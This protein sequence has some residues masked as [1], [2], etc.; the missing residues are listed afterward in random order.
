MSI[1]KITSGYSS[2]KM[3]SYCSKEK[4]D[5]LSGEKI[6]RCT[7]W[8]NNL[9]LAHPEHVA[10]AW[11]VAR[12]GFGKCSGRQYHHASLSLDPKD[13]QAQKITDPEMIRMAEK[14]V[15]EYAPGHDYSIFIHRDKEHPH[16]HILWNSVHS[17]TGLKFHASKEDLRHGMEIKD[18][19]DHEFG[20][21][22]TTRNKIFDRI[23][24]PAKRLHERDQS[25]YLWMEDLKQRIEIIRAHTSDFSTY[26]ALLKQLGV[27]ADP[28]GKEGKV[29]YRFLDIEGKQRQCRE[30]KLGDDYGRETLERHFERNRE[31]HQSNAAKLEHTELD[32]S[33]Q[34]RIE[35]STRRTSSIKE[36]TSTNESNLGS[37]SLTT[38]RVYQLDTS[39]NPTPFK[40]FFQFSEQ[41]RCL[42]ELGERFISPHPAGAFRKDDPHQTIGRELERQQPHDI[43]SI[44]RQHALSERVPITLSPF[45]D[46]DRSS[47]NSPRMDSSQFLHSEDTSEQRRQQ[48]S[49]SPIQENAL[50]TQL[51]EFRHVVYSLTE[52]GFNP[53]ADQNPPR[54]EQGGSDR[55][56]TEYQQGLVQ[57]FSIARARA[58][59][60]YR[61]YSR[62]K[63]ERIEELGKTFSRAI[64]ENGSEIGRRIADQIQ[65]LSQVAQGWY[66][67]ARERLSD[68]QERAEELLRS[69]FELKKEH[70]KQD[71][72]IGT[73]GKSM[74][75]TLEKNKKL[76]P[77]KN[78]FE[79]KNIEWELDADRVQ[80]KQKSKRREH[81][82]GR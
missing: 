2:T 16:A 51:A 21:K 26:Q 55:I 62:N 54:N 24:D 80:E 25:A 56:H 8:K 63:Q 52:R 5:R 6:E 45:S 7:A 36:R 38:D 28:R 30:S 46:F 1:L 70:G 78:N 19:I 23:P 73:L 66:D 34:Q 43:Q 18:S 20:L 35:I 60:G 65:R 27:E 33:D 31:Q 3:I 69:Y 29:S 22:I 10:M 71:L 42:R 57:T 48:Y 64:H 17:E 58:Q 53:G 47:F 77:E 61:E 79:D 82:I 74:G 68:L 11:E 9:G 44:A 41:S 76:I 59:S 12:E 50:N 75:A 14:F 15:Q 13:P 72:A 67:N 49:I 32:P 37:H 81:G 4:I 40:D 39:A